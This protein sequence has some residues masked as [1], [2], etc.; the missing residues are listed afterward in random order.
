MTGYGYK[1]LLEA[2]DRH[3]GER[4]RVKH[5]ND[6]Y[7]RYDIKGRFG[8]IIRWYGSDNIAVRLDDLSNRS[9]QYGYFY[10]AKWEIETIENNNEK[11]GGKYYDC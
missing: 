2:S 8:T 7:Q 3:V 6:K 4:V 9:S 10:F 11:N 1:R 5:T